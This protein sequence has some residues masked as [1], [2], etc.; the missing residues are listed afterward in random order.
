MTTLALPHESENPESTF[1]RD[2][3]WKKKSYAEVIQEVYMHDSSFGV[4]D[5]DME[6]QPN[7]ESDIEEQVRVADTQTGTDNGQTA[8]A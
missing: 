8:D 7:H 2:N 6:E 4:G 5:G 1:L 3:S